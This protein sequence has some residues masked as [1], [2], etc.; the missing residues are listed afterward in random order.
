MYVN[1]YINIVL[2]KESGNCPI[3]EVFKL[4]K[5]PGFLLCYSF[6]ILNTHAVVV[7]LCWYRYPIFF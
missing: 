5:N 2:L 4:C 3:F 7:C 6:A 1:K